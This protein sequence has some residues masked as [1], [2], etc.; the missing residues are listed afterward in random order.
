[1]SCDFSMKT[2]V[3]LGADRVG[4]TSLIERSME[5]TVSRGKTP[6]RLHFSGILP[7]HN[8]P[9]DQFL[10]PLSLGGLQDLDIDVLFCDRFSPDMIFY[11]RYRRQT[12][13]HPVEYSHVV[14]STYMSKSESL[15][16]I[17][18]N[19]QWNGTMEQRHRDELVS[20][21]PRASEWWIRQM[22]SQRKQEHTEYYQFIVNYLFHTSLF[23]PDQI[24]LF[25]DG[26]ENTTH[27]IDV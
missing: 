2:V 22:I 16:V 21:Y 20:D 14:E 25:P 4:K 23:K 19:P 15:H 1:M 12:G 6:Y 9:I 7:H 8:S 18:L 10:D 17:L 5:T 24:S 27:L 13:G 3:V 11:E 26:L